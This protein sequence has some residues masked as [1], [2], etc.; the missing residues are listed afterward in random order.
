MKR[1]GLFGFVAVL[2]TASSLVAQDKP[3][4][5]LTLSGGLACGGTMERVAPGGGAVASDPVDLD[6]V[7]ITSSN[8]GESGAQGW[9]IS[10]GSENLDIVGITTDGTVGADNTAGGLRNTG[11]EKSELTS[12]AGNEGAVSAVVLSFTM[13]ITLAAEGEA[14]IAKVSVQG[15]DFPEGPAG[16]TGSAR[17]FF[18]NGRQG[19]G[20]PVDNNITWTGAT[21]VPSL[22]E[23]AIDLATI[24]APPLCPNPDVTSGLQIIVQAEATGEVADLFAGSV[25]NP[26]GNDE[27]PAVIEVAPGPATVY[28]AIV[29]QSENGVQGWSLS[30]AGEFT[31]VSTDGTVGADASMGGLRNTGFEKSELV[32]PAKNGQGPGAVSAVVLSFT[33]PIT[34][35][36]SGTA[37][38]IALNV[39]GALGDTRQI[40]WNDGLQG[41]GQPVDNVATVAGGTVK[42]FCAQ[43]ADVVFAA[44]PTR[45]VAVGDSNDDGRMDIADPIWILNALF[46]AGPTTSCEAASDAN[47]DGMVDSSDAIYI[48]NY[49]WLSGPAPAGAGGCVEIDPNDPGSV[50]CAENSS[51]C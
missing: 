42:Y 6:C 31:S 33:M 36:P 30:V 9:S 40:R 24:E 45:F 34:L 4:F 20:Q 17:V 27:L 43:G 14:V 41:I 22:G 7:L 13:P 51:S 19:A 25:S 47:S 35:L 21:V 39:D 23:C 16:T 28:G 44:P 18:V 10:V 48:I 12:G 37:T 2:A 11:F 46:R 8:P 50:A 15:G 49:L 5:D 38:V 3:T 1:L 26:D 29:S 32:D